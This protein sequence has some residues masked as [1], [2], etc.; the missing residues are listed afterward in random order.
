[1]SEQCDENLLDEDFGDEEYELGNDEEEALLADDY[2][3]ET[4]SSYKGEEETD[5]VLDLGVTDALDDLEGEEENV[6]YSG[7]TDNRNHNNYY[8]ERHENAVIYHYGQHD[9]E[10]NVGGES[11]NVGSVSNKPDLREKLQ[12]SA[13]KDFY[14]GNGQG[15][16]D[17]DCEE[18]KE[19]RNRFQN[20]RT[21]I[22]PKMNNEIPDSLENVVTSEQSRPLFRGRGRGRGIRG[23]R[24][25]RFIVQN[26]QTFN[27]RFNGPRV[28]MQFENQRPQY[29]APLLEN[30]PQYAPPVPRMN[31]PNQQITPFPQNNAQ[32]V[33][34]YGQFSMN[35]PQQHP[36]PQFVE[37]RPPFNPNQFQGMIGPPGP[38]LMGPRPEFDPR[39]PLLGTAPQQNYPPNQP[40]PQFIIHNQPQHFQNQGQ[41]IPGNPGPMPMQGNQLPVV[42]VNQ[43]P[44][45]QGNQRPMM[46]P[47]QGVPLLRNPGSLMPG[48][49]RPP[50][51]NQIPVM[52]SHP[53]APNLPNPVTF[54]NVPP[55]QDPH[56]CQEARPVYDS[57]PVYNDQPPPNQY[58]N[59]PPVPP[60]QPTPGNV[61]NPLPP[62]HKI[63]INP[64]FRGAVQPTQ[65]SRLP[66]DSAT[67]QQQPQQQQPPPPS[68]S[69]SQIVNESFIHQQSSQFQD[70]R[71]Y[72][73]PSAPS[74][75]QR[76]YNQPNVQQ[77]KSD[78]PYAYFSDVWQENKP[79]KTP[80]VNPSSSFHNESSYNK[81]NYYNNFDNNYKSQNQWDSR[82]S[83]QTCCS[84][85]THNVMDYSNEQREHQPSYRER[86][87][88]SRSNTERPRESRIPS[89][90][91][92]Y[93]NENYDLNRQQRTSIGSRAAPSSTLR[94][95]VR[96][97][98]KRSPEG[99]SDRGPRESSPK[100]PKL[101]NRNLHEVKT[102][103]TLPGATGD[104]KTC[105]PEGPEMREYRKKLEEQKRMR[106]KFLREKENRRKIAAMEKQYDKEKAEIAADA[107]ES[108]QETIPVSVITGVTKDLKVRPAVSRGRSRPVGAQTTEGLERSSGMRI[109]RTI[110]TVQP[111]LQP[112]VSSKDGEKNTSATSAV[113]T[114]K[115]NDGILKRQSPQQHGIRRVVIHKTLPNTQKVATTIQKTVSNLQKPVQKIGGNATVGVQK[116]I[117]KK[118]LGGN[119]QV[120]VTNASKNLNMNNPK[121]VVNT[122]SNQR[123]VLQKSPQQTRKLTEIKSNVVR[124]E[125][126]AASTT[127]NQIRRMCQGIGTLESIRMTEGSATIVFK[128]QSAALVFH[129]KYQRKMLDLSLIT[130]HLVPQA[131]GNRPIPTVVKKS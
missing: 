125:N 129:K 43:G 16:E 46:Q 81:D 91:S 82:E 119:A 1:M 22:S 99:Y 69:S 54:E 26:I 123:V 11:E 60:A 29:R 126:L 67:Q 28:P 114:I 7:V 78:D 116:T 87:V 58:N 3:L 121:V 107:E 15:M 101:S 98:Q 59:G 90:N 23:S 9:Y 36:R 37:N 120:S 122:Q 21:I 42:P 104:K 131:T 35:G 66:W 89:T 2:E 52:Q 50:I 95:I 8:E 51:H 44:P 112:T 86:D 5:D 61:P 6:N 24:G 79:Q 62:G 64:H 102:V 127:E 72:N 103:D 57:R 4:Q 31:I 92:S 84:Q 25:G 85:S 111:T 88:H 113:S 110:Q 118:N 38:R 17:D 77:N 30:R 45:M 19:R 18:A 55:Y 10:E 94:G 97:Q 93:R 27:P 71:P 33:P 75:P 40:P 124:I 106:E 117:L 108:N 49:L 20:E 41:P 100:R 32:M 12:K 109:V 115:V 80:S 83:Y 70:Q 128:T 130:V 13:Q 73:Q 68:V 56:F 76:D 53:N 74:Q 34:P 47:H 63:L 105:E 14:V 65:D 48:H 39:G 96:S